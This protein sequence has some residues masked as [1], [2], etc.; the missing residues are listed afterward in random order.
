MELSTEQRVIVETVQTGKNVQVDAVPGAGKTT[1]LIEVARIILLSGRK[2]IGVTYS[3]SLRDEWK[4][5]LDMRNSAQVYTFHSLATLLWSTVVDR[6]YGME[7]VL[8][9]PIQKHVDFDTLLIDE[10]SR[11]QR[12]VLRP[13]DGSGCHYVS[14]HR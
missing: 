7:Q 13:V 3:R 8:K 10:G 4:S 11:H 9:S 14:S 6:D 1:T 2:V 12:L 5:R